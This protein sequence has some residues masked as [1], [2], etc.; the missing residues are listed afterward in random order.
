[1][2]ALGQ[3]LYYEMKVSTEVK[4]YDIRFIEIECS[5]GFDSIVRLDS[6]LTMFKYGVPS[7]LD[8]EILL[9]SLSNIN[10]LEIKKEMDDLYIHLE[11][12]KYFSIPMTA[13][14]RI[15]FLFELFLKGVRAQPWKS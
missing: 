11:R 15:K 3:H 12:L 9:K 14:R 5:I 13:E 1:M 4:Y 2:A 7:E 10:F 8:A 6:T